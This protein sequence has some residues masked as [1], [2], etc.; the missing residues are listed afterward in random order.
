M[1]ES[2]LDARERQHHF[3]L[4]PINS[5]HQ[6]VMRSKSR[7]LPPLAALASGR[8]ASLGM[9]VRRASLGM[10]VLLAACGNPRSE[11]AVAQALNDAASEINGLKSDLA[12]LQAQMD[13]LRTVVAKHDTTISRMAEANHIP[14]AR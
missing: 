5:S 13:S 11:A 1:K 10:T 12:D 4:L 14:I 9:T 8:A 3:A 7:S 6:I 2:N